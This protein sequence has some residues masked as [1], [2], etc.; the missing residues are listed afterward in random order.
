[1]ARKGAIALTVPQHA[2]ADV[3]KHVQVNQASKCSCSSVDCFFNCAG[4]YVFQ[5][6]TF[7]P[8]VFFFA[9]ERGY[10][11]I[12][13]NLHNT[14]KQ[15]TRAMVDGGKMTIFAIF[16]PDTETACHS[17]DSSSSCTIVARV[18]QCLAIYV[19][20]PPPS[21]VD[22]GSPV[23]SAKVSTEKRTK[24][25]ELHFSTNGGAVLRE[26]QP[27]GSERSKQT[28]KALEDARES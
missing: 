2:P 13:A 22:C 3:D 27:W 24:S 7:L 17:F 23:D 16:S 6:S 21:P 10:T 12:R 26:H 14:V 18:Q 25:N 20:H 8:R 19:T 28:L 9:Y 15:G 11:V 5:D 1:M 4:S